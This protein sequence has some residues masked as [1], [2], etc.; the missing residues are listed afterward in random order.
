MINQPKVRH[1][2]NNFYDLKMSEGR[3]VDFYFSIINTANVDTGTVTQIKT[4]LHIRRAVIT[5]LVSRYKF[6]PAAESTYQRDD[7]VVL[8][9]VRDL[10]SYKIA[11]EDYFVIK[12]KKFLIISHEF[13]DGEG[14]IFIVRHVQNEVPLQDKTINIFHHL[15]LDSNYDQ[16]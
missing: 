4:L 5:S 12:G 7:T 15:R 10:K 16:S 11:K 9:D 8:V 2:L 1:M 3:P 6:F 14:H 13:L